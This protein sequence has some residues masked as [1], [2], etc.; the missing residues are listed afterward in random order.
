MSVVWD[1]YGA[2]LQPTSNY[3]TYISTTLP[4]TLTGVYNVFIVCDYYHQV[5]ELNKSN[6]VAMAAQP[7]TIISQPPD[8]RPV[9]LQAPASAN[10]GSAFLVSWGVTNRGIGD[11]A[12]GQWNDGLILS[13]SPV[14]G[15][16]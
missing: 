7:V 1:S 6:N 16:S 5:F 2:F 14:L 10:A 13:Q 8:L 3:N 11:T 9:S 4:D 12:V 15:S